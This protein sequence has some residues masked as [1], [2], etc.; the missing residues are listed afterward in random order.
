VVRLLVDRGCPVNAPDNK[1]VTPFDLALFSNNASLCRALHFAGAVL[2]SRNAMMK[3]VIASP[4]FLFKEKD[5]VGIME[6][7]K[8]VSQIS[9]E[10]RE[11]AQLLAAAIINK[12]GLMEEIMKDETVARAVTIGYDDKGNTPLHLA[13]ALNSDALPALLAVVEDVNVQNHD[14]DTAL[15]LLCSST[16]LALKLLER[17]EAFVKAGSD[18][19]LGN[20]LGATP[21]HMACVSWN[22]SLAQELLKAGADANAVDS[23]G[24]SPLQAVLES[25]DVLWYRHGTSLTLGVPNGPVGNEEENEEYINQLPVMPFD[26]ISILLKVEV[27]W[28]LNLFFSFP[29]L[30]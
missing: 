25:H 14:G 19:N 13:A 22:A 10:M 28:C 16:K 26:T 3:K 8:L 2:P 1:G 4:Q 7:I 9:K 5:R 12:S 21:L 15:L 18:V 27:S 29:F 20:N 23:A 6:W 17:V 24:I 11:S 30:I